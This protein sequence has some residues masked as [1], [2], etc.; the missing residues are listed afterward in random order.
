M[1]GKIIRGIG[2]F[3]YIHAT[4][5]KV[6]ACRARGIFRRLGIKPLVGDNAD[7]TITHEKDQEGS[8]TGI[9][10]RKNVL[11]RPAAT[12]I[13]QALLVF[14]LRQPDPDFYLLDKLLVY[15]RS[16]KI[17]VIIYFNKT[18]LDIKGE[19]RICTK[20]YKDAG[21]EVISGFMPDEKTV[22]S[23]RERLKKKTTILAG[24]SGVGKSTLVNSVFVTEHMKVGELSAKI[25]RGKQTTRHAELLMLDTGGHLM[26]TPGFSSFDLS[27][28]N[29]DYRKL[30]EFY[31][32]FRPYHGKCKYT[33]C[34]HVH[35][36]ADICAVK[37][38]VQQ[39]KISSFRY[40]GY[41][42]IYNEIYAARRK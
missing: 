8:L 12:N 1:T 22:A 34:S 23:I 2:G 18:D 16:Q 14:S 30:A 41:C 28:L 6:Y 35:E 39:G 11:V 36:A 26:D 5:D 7:F 15:M 40:E 24:P 20:I 10:T 29:L 21:Y 4:D 19:E 13:D 3:Y 37:A 9:R 27:L 32:E 42:R 38:A 25:M 33:G 31:E 17:S